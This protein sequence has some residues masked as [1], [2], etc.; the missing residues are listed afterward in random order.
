MVVSKK[1]QTK[2]QYKQIEV[3]Q[4]F[5]YLGSLIIDDGYRNEE[6]KTGTGMAKEIFW[7]H[8]DLFYTKCS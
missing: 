8:R 6:I 5:Q 4:Q 3:V 7:K 1:E 2:L